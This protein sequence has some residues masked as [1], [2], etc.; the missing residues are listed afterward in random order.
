MCVFL[1]S[2]RLEALSSSFLM[3]SF[4]SLSIIPL[5][6]NAASKLSL[7]VNKNSIC[8]QLP[9]K[10]VNCKIVNKTRDLEERRMRIAQTYVCVLLYFLLK[11]TAFD[12]PS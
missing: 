6:Y 9:T 12:V 5:V 7:T 2:L 11:A 3:T 4:T 1:S 10:A 8:Y